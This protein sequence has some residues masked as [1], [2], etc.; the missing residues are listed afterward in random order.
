MNKIYVLRLEKE[1]WWVS[2]SSVPKKRIKAY[3]NNQQSE[4]VEKYPA[5]EVAEIIPEKSNSINLRQKVLQMMKKHGWENVRGPPWIHVNLSGPP[6]ELQ[7]LDV[8]THQMQST[9]PIQK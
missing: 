7:N 9:L 6:E 8:E 4:W 1:K 3:F 2:N 5:I